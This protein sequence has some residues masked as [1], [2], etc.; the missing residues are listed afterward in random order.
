MAGGCRR[1]SMFVLLGGGSQDL[2]ARQREGASTSAGSGSPLP[3][4]GPQ[5]LPL[6]WDRQARQRLSRRHACH[7]PPPPPNIHGWEREVRASTLHLRYR[8]EGQQNPKR[9]ESR[10]G[11]QRPS[12]HMKPHQV[13]GANRLAQAGWRAGSPALQ[14]GAG[15]LHWPPLPAVPASVLHSLPSARLA[16]VLGAGTNCAHTCTAV[17][18]AC[19]ASAAPRPAAVQPCA[20]SLHCG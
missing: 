11:D 19:T 6:Q 12:K 20:G 13:P 8:V 14:A 18:Q 16:P 1:I 7:P 2:Q 17:R 9:S 3:A 5:S 15:R 10:Q 4:A